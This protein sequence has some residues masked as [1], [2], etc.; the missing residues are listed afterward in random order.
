MVN[1]TTAQVEFLRIAI[2]RRNRDGDANRRTS[3]H[4][5]GRHRRRGSTYNIVATPAAGYYFT[6]WTGY[7]ATDVASPSSASTTLTVS[8]TENLVAGFATI[9][10]YVVTTA[11]DD[12]GSA[13][14]ANCPGASCSLRDALA[15]ATAAGAGN[16][17]FSSTVFTA[18][19]TIT[20]GSGLT[21]PTLTTITGPT[22]GS[23]YTLKN[24]VTVSAEPIISSPL[25]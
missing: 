21:I 6:G 22:S 10:G 3:C 2:G 13:N 5:F 18:P 19:T 1:Q 17:T 8:G 23:G 24:L 7:Y 4:R 9:P 12:S 14:A 20:L 11:T 15:A 16:I 25:L